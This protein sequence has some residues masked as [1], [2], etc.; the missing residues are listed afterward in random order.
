MMHTQ[1]TPPN[2]PGFRGNFRGG[3]NGIKFAQH[4]LGV[5]INHDKHLQTNPFE[6]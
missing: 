2:P 1:Y 3:L 6:T 5:W 4:V